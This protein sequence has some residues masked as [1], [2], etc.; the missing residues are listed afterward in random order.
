MHPMLTGP[1]QETYYIFICNGADGFGIVISESL[2]I[3][4]QLSEVFLTNIE[5]YLQVK[6]TLWVHYTNVLKTEENPHVL[7]MC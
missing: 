2:A 7:T 5:M 1:S 3:C 4:Q 6:F